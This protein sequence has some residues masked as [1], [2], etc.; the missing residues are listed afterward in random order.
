MHILWT[1]YFPFELL[2]QISIKD[3]IS[4]LGFPLI[5][6]QLVNGL[7]LVLGRYSLDGITI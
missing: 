4:G 7:N 3:F 6:K 5:E 2:A 1:S